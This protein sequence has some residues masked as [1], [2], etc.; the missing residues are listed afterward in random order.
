MA[1]LS[2]RP[3]IASVAMVLLASDL[4]LLTSLARL[5]A[6][7]SFQ[8]PPSQGASFAS[9]IQSPPKFTA[10]IAVPGSPTRECSPF[11]LVSKLT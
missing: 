4:P 10:D 9:I 5:V 8:G 11:V 6:L 1:S 7:P 2:H 3:P